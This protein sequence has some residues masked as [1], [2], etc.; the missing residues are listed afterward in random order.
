M[1]RA[2][3][4]YLHA[5]FLRFLKKIIVIIVIVLFL[6]TLVYLIGEYFNK[7]NKKTQEQISKIEMSSSKNASLI[8]TKEMVNKA[9]KNLPPIKYENSQQIG[10]QYI[11][12]ILTKEADAASLSN[13]V[14]ES[15]VDKDE[16]IALNY[17]DVSNIP[18]IHVMEIIVT[19]NSV[20][21]RQMYEFLNSVSTIS[22][23]VPVWQNVESRK[24][25]QNVDGDTL[26]S[27]NNGQKIAILGHRITIHWFFIR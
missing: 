23:G 10:R 2:Y 19:F 16:I 24:I 11:I 25:V 7:N 3:Q 21:H 5:K 6:L 22:S 18:R 20:L 1:N 17:S 12:E 15:I 26:E 8:A 9:F 4:F 27:I 13:F 14:I